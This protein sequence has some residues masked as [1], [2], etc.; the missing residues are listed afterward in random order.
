[1]QDYDEE[2]SSEFYGTDAA[3]LNENNN[4]D[5]ENNNNDNDKVDND[6]KLFSLSS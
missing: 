3:W 6:D 1:M 5:D 2:V 4:N